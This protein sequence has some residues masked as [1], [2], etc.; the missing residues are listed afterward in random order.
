MSGRDHADA[1][2]GARA[3]L[4]AD[5]NLNVAV[6]RGQKAHQPLDRKAAKTI[7]S[8]RRHLGLIDAEGFGRRGLRQTPFVDDAVDRVG[9]SQLGLPLLRVGIAE[10]GKYVAAAAG[11]VVRRRAPI[12][13]RLSVPHNP[14]ARPVG[15]IPA[16]C[17]NGID[18]KERVRLVG[19]G[20]QGAD[21]GYH[22]L[23]GSQIKPQ[24]L[25]FE[26]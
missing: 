24:V 17:S 25:Q 8:Q 14:S 22:K 15:S 7:V 13:S 16:T 4:S 21:T 18:D 11:N 20:R 23:F 3:R 19:G 26:W 6:Q 5:D 9:E 1:R 10:I 2:R 12:S